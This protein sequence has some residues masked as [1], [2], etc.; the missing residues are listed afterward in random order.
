MTIITDHSAHT[1][2]LQFERELV[3][4]L[5]QR[6]L[7]AER[8]VEKYGGRLA[9]AAHLAVVGRAGCAAA[10]QLRHQ[11]HRHRSRRRGRWRRVSSLLGSTGE[12]VGGHAE[13]RGAEPAAADRAEA[14]DPVRQA[15][16]PAVHQPPR[17][18][19]S[20]RA[21]G[22][23]RRG[24]DRVL[25]RLQPAPEDLLR[26]RLAHGRGDRG[27]VPRDR[28]HPRV[29]PRCRPRRPRRV[30]ATGLDILEVVVAG[31]GSLA[32][33][34]EASEWSIELAGVDV[35][36]ASAAVDAF[37]AADVVEV[38]RMGKRG[39]RT[40]DARADVVALEARA[41]DDGESRVRY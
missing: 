31:Q 38:E 34:L 2:A 32:D 11:H 8:G 4:R 24:A 18:R 13:P 7:I 36:T 37:L 33:R 39:L 1:E 3:D 22:A 41:G 10:P 12:H 6:R 20:L 17:L 5:E 26:Q 27:R 23:T 15:G 40:F 21:R 30:A 35:A 14:A 28:A 16:A 19:P 29:R 9:F 25:V